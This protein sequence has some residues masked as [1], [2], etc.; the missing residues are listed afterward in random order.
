MFDF[1]WNVIQFYQNATETLLQYRINEC[2]F[3][4]R[5]CLV[6]VEWLNEFLWEKKLKP[7]FDSQFPIK[8]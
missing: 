8:N 5:V 1:I 2:F 6:N 7:V 4:V 3:H